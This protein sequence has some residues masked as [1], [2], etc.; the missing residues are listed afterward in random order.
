MNYLH[1]NQKIIFTSKIYFTSFIVHCQY[2]HDRKNHRK[3]GE[4]TCELGFYK[5]R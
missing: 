5:G 4:E 1:K 2:F 3:K